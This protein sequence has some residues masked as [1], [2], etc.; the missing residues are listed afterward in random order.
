MG[1]GDDDDTFLERAFRRWD[2]DPPEDDLDEPAAGQ[3]ANDAAGDTAELPELSDAGIGRMAAEERPQSATSGDWARQPAEVEPMVESIPGAVSE[4]RVGDV[5]A[6]EI[7]ASPSP[8]AASPIPEAQLTP[9]PPQPAP[10][11]PS[12]F[13]LA[14]VD[15]AFKKAGLIW[16]RTGAFPGGQ[17][18]WHV[19]VDGAAYV[20]TGGDEQPDPGLDDTEVVVVVRSKDTTSRLLV[21]GCQASRVASADDDWSAATAEL[22]KVRLNLHEA[23]A[24]PQRWR[25]EP[26]YRIYRLRPSADRFIEGPGSYPT[27]SGRAAP[28]AT[29]ATTATSRPWI[30]HRRGGSGRPLS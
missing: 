9:G 23:A 17:A 25:D 19:W 21:L 14:L 26:A 24:A 2:P 20:V 4:T 18:L 7:L 13:D 27:A 30:M 1:T 29:P 8:V 16:V 12:R 5:P 22:A 11:V 15:E 28:V 10:F 6:T 3:V